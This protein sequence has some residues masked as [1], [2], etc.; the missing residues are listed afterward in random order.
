MLDVFFYSSTIQL[1]YPGDLFVRAIFLVEGG[2]IGGKNV[3]GVELA[4]IDVGEESGS[5]VLR[6]GGSVTF[7]VTFYDCPSDTL[8]QFS[9]VSGPM[10]IFAKV[11]VD[12]VL[13][14]FG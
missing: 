10:V 11:F 1:G 7:V 12:Y 6:G 8:S 4:G 9:D 3:L 14:G 2:T 5:L 13:D